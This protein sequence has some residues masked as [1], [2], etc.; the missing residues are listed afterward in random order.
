MDKQA[1][2][3]DIASWHRWFAVECNN[4]AWDLADID[5]RS[6]AED[7]EMVRAAQAAGYHWSIVGAPV[8]VARAEMTLAH[9]YALTGRAA[10]AMES[11]RRCMAH[12]ER[13][14]GADWD[15]AFAH[16]EMALAAVVGGDVALH[17][18][19]YE[20][21]RAAGAAIADEGD[22]TAFA[23][24]FDRVPSEVTRT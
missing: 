1:T 2:P 13:E 19:H 10:P 22:R 4:R 9:V 3:E 7:D 16:A 11:A 12:F 20:A 8:N 15:L 21:A 24:V 5:K 18:Q 17:A 14:G 23:A 6:E